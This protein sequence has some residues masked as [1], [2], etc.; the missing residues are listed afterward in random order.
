MGEC[1]VVVAI[2]ADDDAGVAGVG[3]AG[4]AADQE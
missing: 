4:P 2:I 3:A 1:V